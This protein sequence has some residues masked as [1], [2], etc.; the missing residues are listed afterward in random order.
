MCRSSLGYGNCCLVSAP[1]SLERRHLLTSYRQSSLH[2]QC[3]NSHISHVSN[4][5]VTIS[6]S[7]DFFFSLFRFIALSRVCVL[8]GKLRGAHTHTLGQQCNIKRIG[9]RREKKN[10]DARK[11]CNSIVWDG[12]CG[13]AD[14]ICATS[15]RGHSLAA[16]PATIL[17]LSQRLR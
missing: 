5:T 13:D 6:F 16:D 1:L 9:E 15:E 4:S 11:R 7:F 10:A 14:A 3:V 12:R 2:L 8:E 17:S